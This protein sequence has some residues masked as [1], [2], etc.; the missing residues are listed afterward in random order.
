[1][2]EQQMT[3]TNRQEYKEKIDKISEWTKTAPVEK[4]SAFYENEQVQEAMKRLAQ[5]TEEY[6]QLIEKYKMGETK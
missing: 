5:N 2:E 4:V 3:E 6:E 1:M